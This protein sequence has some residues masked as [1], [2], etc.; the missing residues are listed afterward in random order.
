MKYITMQFLSIK[1]TKFICIH[2]IESIRKSVDFKSMNAF[3][4][5]IIR[6]KRRL[7]TLMYLPGP[8]AGG[9]N[10][11]QISVFFLR[12]NLHLNPS[13]THK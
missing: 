9:A 4:T 2:V 6:M 1:H 5:F 8:P 11:T 10:D 3:I 13:Q 12:G 7:L